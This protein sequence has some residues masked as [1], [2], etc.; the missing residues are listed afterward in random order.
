MTYQIWLACFSMNEWM[1]DRGFMSLSTV[2]Q[3]YREKGRVNM[4]GSVQ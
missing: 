1:D 4:K 2:V 3:S